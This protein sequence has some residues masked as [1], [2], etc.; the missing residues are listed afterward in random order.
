[1]TYRLFSVRHFSE[2]T[3]STSHFLLISSPSINVSLSS[4]SVCFF[5]LGY[6]QVLFSFSLY[7]LISLIVKGFC[8][9]VVFCK[10]S[11]DLQLGRFRTGS[12]W[13]L[14]DFTVLCCC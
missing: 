7:F 9:W 11:L 3:A 10:S 6:Q 8:K 13:Q 2:N 12:D 5:F 1:M 14:L 4:S